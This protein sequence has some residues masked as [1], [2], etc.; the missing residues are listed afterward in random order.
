MTSKNA[1]L[2]FVEAISASGRGYGASL[3]A[4][5]V[6]LVTHL[7]IGTRHCLLSRDTCFAPAR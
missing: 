6:I 1:R 4:Q 7:S 5:S 3:I 2:T